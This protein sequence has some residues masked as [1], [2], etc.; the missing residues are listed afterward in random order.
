MSTGA[1]VSVFTVWEKHIP[2]NIQLANE[3]QERLITSTSSEKSLRKAHDWLNVCLTSHAQCNV[4]PSNDEWWPSRLIEI[5][6]SNSGFDIRLLETASS[7]PSGPYMTLSHSWGTAEFLQLT[8]QNKEML[9]AG[10][11]VDV[12]PKTFQDAIVVAKALQCRYIWIDSLCI[13]QNS[14][15]DWQQ[16]ATLMSE[17]YQH[18]I[19]N[20]AATHA[21]DSS[22]GLFT[23]GF[24]PQP[25]MIQLARKTSLQ[26]HLKNVGM[27]AKSS[28]D[29]V[30]F[31]DSNIWLNSVEKSPLLKRGWVLQERLLARRV[32]HFAKR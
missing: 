32:L 3:T 11:L 8:S 27:K 25:C 2:R 31:Q 29:T 12:L 22:K 4:R 13:I 19:C 5:V 14:S 10:F 7:Q 18:A 24:E 16:E 28:L 20:I 30:H 23:D 9:K 6:D 26:S 17:V 21:S 15:D 1:L